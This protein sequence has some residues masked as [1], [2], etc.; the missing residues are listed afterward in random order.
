MARGNNTRS[1]T[2]R[3]LAVPSVVEIPDTD[4]ALDTDFDAVEPLAY[5]G[6]THYGATVRVASMHDMEG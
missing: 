6:T 1:A 3:R 4:L 2:T 5:F